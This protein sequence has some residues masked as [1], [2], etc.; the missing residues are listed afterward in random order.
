MKYE[1]NKRFMALAHT[2][3]QWSK[4]PEV[5]TGCV[6]VHDRRV[7]AIGYNGFPASVTDDPK[8]LADKHM[9][10]QLMVHAE[11][12]AISFFREYF[13][14]IEFSRFSRD[15]KLTLYCTRPPCYSCAMAIKDFEGI[16][17]VVVPELPEGSSWE[18]SCKEGRTLL[19]NTRI[20]YRYLSWPCA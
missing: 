3:A 6:I 18:L 12:N 13:G 11:V 8:W 16:A 10:N 9:K 14:S 15:R 20:A 7:L 1:W 4:D 2:V 5:K 19:L 17:E